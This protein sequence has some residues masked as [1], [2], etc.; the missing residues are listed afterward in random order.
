M[1]GQAPEDLRGNVTLLS[2]SAIGSPA[3]FSTA[4]KRPPSPPNRPL[5]KKRS[6]S[7]G[8]SMV[9]STVKKNILLQ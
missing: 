5:G 8:N 6:V 3:A 9:T 4:V 2:H 1:E 7:Y